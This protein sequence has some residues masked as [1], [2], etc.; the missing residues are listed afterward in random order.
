MHPQTSFSFQVKRLLSFFV[1]LLILL[2]R[3]PTQAE[4]LPPEK[5]PEPLKPWVDWVLLNHEDRACPFLY[6]EQER[7]CS[8]PSKLV[9]DLTEKGGVFRQHWSVQ[10][11]TFVPLPG[12]EDRWP[13]KVKLDGR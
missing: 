2:L 11:D 6:G 3:I 12:D 1:F 9:L 10:A 5:V 7:P 4:P 13:Q 8:W